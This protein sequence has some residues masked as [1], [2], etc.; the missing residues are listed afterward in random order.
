MMLEAGRSTEWLTSILLVAFALT[1][2]LP[3]DTLNATHAYTGFLILGF[4]E[5]LLILLLGTIGSVRLVALYV[6]GAWHRTPTF[7]LIGAM[8]GAMAFAMMA[9]T[10]LYPILAM[11]GPDET[12]PMSTAF[13]T[14]FILFVFDVIAV[15]RSAAEQTRY[16]IM[17]HGAT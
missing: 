9:M 4:N 5:P 15:Y 1:L 16:R 17:E 14:Y 3:G 2:A 11:G 12:T 6:N 8:L 10:F 13:S 7:R